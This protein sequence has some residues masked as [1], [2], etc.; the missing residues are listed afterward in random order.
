ME[1]ASPHCAL[2]HIASPL[3]V[4]LRGGFVVAYVVYVSVNISILAR[5][6]SFKVIIFVVGL[7]YIAS[8]KV[9]IFVV[10]LHY[11]ASFKVI[12]FVVGLHYIASFKVIIFV[13]GLRSLS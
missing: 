9:I 2:H 1:F 7:H 6:A 12:I 11:I 13:V 4:S 10:G 3:L 5:T 8:F